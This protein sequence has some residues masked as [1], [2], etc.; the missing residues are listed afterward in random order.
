[1]APKTPS[2]DL[3][4][5]TKNLKAL[6]GALEHS[7]TIQRTRLQEIVDDLVS[8][9][10]LSRA[11]ADG[12]LNQLLTSSKDYS[13]AL[14]ATAGKLV[15]TVRKVPGMPNK[16]SRAPRAVSKTAPEPAVVAD[17]PAEPIPGYDGMTV[18]EIKPKLSGLSAGALRKVRER[19]VAGKGRKTVLEQIDH[20]LGPK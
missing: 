4:V 13:Q 10:S 15:D 11:D 14:L 20:L 5:V 6:Q 19:E 16:P 7:L 8:R 3:T 17:A 18:A 1:M 2:V 12:L 9:G